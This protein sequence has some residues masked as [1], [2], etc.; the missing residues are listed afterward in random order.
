M[1]IPSESELHKISSER[2][3][4]VTANKLEVKTDITKWFSAVTVGKRQ[5]NTHTHTQ[6]EEKYETG[7]KENRMKET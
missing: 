6:K 2:A 1:E 5:R 4:N 7:K 3:S